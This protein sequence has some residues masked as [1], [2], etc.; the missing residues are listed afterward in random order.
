M[1]KSSFDPVRPLAATAET[2]G[3]ISIRELRERFLIRWPLL[4]VCVVLLPLIAVVLTSFVPL[5]YKS[6]AQLLIRHESGSAGLLDSN[7]RDTTDASG[8]ASAE[9]LHSV[10]V[11]ERMVEEV[12]VVDA[13]VARPAYKV[14]LRRMFILLSPLLPKQKDDVAPSAALALSQL[15]YDIKDS[16]KV[17]ALQTELRAMGR[18]DELIE[19]TLSSTN[20]KKVAAMTNA[21]CR[22][23]IAEH[24]LRSETEAK[25]TYELLVATE[26]QTL[27]QIQETAARPVDTTKYEP[28]ISE[29]N[30]N[31]F[32]AQ[33][34]AESLARHVA[35]L[36]VALVE[37]RR[38]YGENSP[39]V[40]R[41]KKTLDETKAVYNRQQ[42]LDGFAS[43]LSSIKERERDALLNL[44]LARR[45]E[46]GLS[47]AEAALPPKVT[48][49]LKLIHFGLPA[50]VSLVLGIILGC[51]AII[52]SDLFDDRV[53]TKW[54]IKPIINPRPILS[55][56]SGDKS[57][58][59]AD[60]GHL[61]TVFDEI[62][63]DTG[64]V[65][66]FV[67][68]NAAEDSSKLTLGLAQL[69][70]ANPR[71]RVVLVDANFAQRKLTDLLNKREARGLA[72]ALAENDTSLQSVAVSNSD[73]IEFIP[74]GKPTSAEG[75]TL[76]KTRWTQLLG[77]LKGRASVII[78]DAGKDA[79]T[80][81]A[82]NADF[83]VL[84]VQSGVTRTEGFKQAVADLD[85]R[86]NQW[87]GTVFLTE[88]RK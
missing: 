2:E 7:F 4:L 21:L 72:D 50:G 32:R 76:V 81:F 34:L 60:L 80:A 20:A 24:N 57:S 49:L 40:L 82:T 62:G 61:L 39:E 6:T 14:L 55:N 18:E 88:K 46:T 64:K 63:M 28:V 38:T 45:N 23:F 43:I 70:A 42:S 37:T 66:A 56:F 16:I 31:A 5:T 10:P 87:L 68:T 77:E 29:Q 1:S 83:V 36:E 59:H 19:I 79:H 11:I 67:G 9:L 33:P 25:Q 75:L 85:S 52:A 65:C 73:G 78:V 12:G 47:V 35:D 8:P 71:L 48:V 22:A 53:R 3:T 58:R 27:E 51:G 84:T 86:G 54:D 74:A 69:L 41:A 44:E 26:K 15:A 13:D 17:T 30:G